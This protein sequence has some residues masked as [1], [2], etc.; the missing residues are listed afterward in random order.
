MTLR[1]VKRESG[2][3]IVHKIDSSD[4][5]GVSDEAL[6]VLGLVEDREMLTESLTADHQRLV[7]SEG[8][9]SELFV[10]IPLWRGMG[11]AAMIN[12]VDSRFYEG[13][14]PLSED[15]RCPPTYIEYELWDRKIKGLSVEE[16][17]NLLS[18]T[19]TVF[20][21]H[22]RLALKEGDNPDNPYLYYS[23]LPYDEET[24]LRHEKTQLRSLLED[25]A[26]YERLNPK[27]NLAHISVADFVILALQARV[28]GEEMQA[29]GQMNLPYMGREP[30]Y[31]ESVIGS[32]S[33]LS[34]GRLQLAWTEGRHEENAGI[35]RS[36]GLNG[37]YRAA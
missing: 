33:M 5:V 8:R 13:R 3:L 24:A 32:A 26:E 2:E 6:R 23:G 4:Q 14:L 31:G 22:A 36:V 28:R 29:S 35:G 9:N 34:D 1:G 17:N 15:G 25:Q 30:V 10:K 20:A 27:L 12:L 7:A 19:K 37:G 21:A 18:P 11:L 16:I